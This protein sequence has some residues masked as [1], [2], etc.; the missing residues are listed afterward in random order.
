MKPFAPRS[1][2]YLIRYGVPQEETRGGILIPEEYRVRANEGEV[3]A[4]GPGRQIPLYKEERTVMS[5]GVGDR[6]LYIGH[7]LQP[8]DE[9]VGLVSDEAIL[10][11][12]DEENEDL[13]PANDWVTM[14]GFVRVAETKG[15]LVVPERFRKRV[16]KGVIRAVGPGSLRVRGPRQGTRCPCCVTMGVSE[17]ELLVGR[18]VWWD[19]GARMVEV[20][21]PS[22]ET[23]LMVRAG[24]LAAIEETG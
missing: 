18:T 16:K 13:L 19:A 4:V 5:A 17:N 1:S 3:L 21:L 12:V 8:C 6:V 11:I 23:L 2:W 15:G 22:G 24:D 7:E 20:T 9:E 10:G 14:S